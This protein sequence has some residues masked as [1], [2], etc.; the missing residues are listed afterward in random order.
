MHVDGDDVLESVGLLEP[1][2]ESGPSLTRAVERDPHG[3]SVARL[4]EQSRRLESG[5]AEIAGDIDLRLL[6][7]VVPT[8]DLDEQV[9]V[10][11]EITGMLSVEA[12]LRFVA[13]MSTLALSR[14]RQQTYYHCA[15]AAVQSARRSKERWTR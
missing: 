2:C 4:G 7:E 8:G 5:D 9:V 10:L 12:E 15:A 1:H 6:L 14:A 3:A 13:H 11:V